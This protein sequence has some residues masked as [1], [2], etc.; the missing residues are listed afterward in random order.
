MA[1]KLTIT[2]LLLASVQNVFLQS[3]E[4]DHPV[5][6]ATPPPLC[7]DTEE[8]SDCGNLCEDNCNN[9][10]EPPVFQLFS[11]LNSATNPACQPGCYCKPGL[12]RNLNGNCVMNTPNVCGSGELVAKFT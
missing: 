5:N 9:R 1:V 6:P 8:F 12:I 7:V 2:I 3:A 11:S 10:C 4:L